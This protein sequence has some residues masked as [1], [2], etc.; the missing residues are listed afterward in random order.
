[1]KICSFIPSATE[2]VYALG[3]GENLCGVTHE[4]DYPP[5]AKLKPVVI[6]SILDTAR[7]SQSEIDSKVVESMTH[8]HG[9]YTIDKELLTRVTPDVV[10]TQELCDV[11]S[12][13]LRDVLS[14]VASLS[15]TCRVI[16]LRPRGLDGVLEDI[17]TV[18][19]ACGA[20][21]AAQRL[22]SS[23]RQRIQTVRERAAQLPRRRVFCVEWFDPVFASG[24]WVPEMVEI[25][26][27]HDSLGIAGQDSRKIPWERVVDYDPEVLILMPCGF[28][29]ERTLGDIH[30]LKRNDGWGSMRAVRDGEV[31]ATDGS[32]FFSR[33][34]PRLVDGLELMSK[35]IHPE[36]FGNDMQPGKAARLEMH[37]LQDA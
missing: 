7:M 4:C 9:L 29:L 17:L 25:S 36:E 37:V 11:C 13:S 19:E 14:T 30:V 21:T 20:P 12:V 33:P 2:I 23:L 18:G 31:F 8:G 6:R 34:G 27:G 22:A 16:S 3:L 1:M 32:S 15:Q 35:M 24:H 10:I 5:E 28:D 26:G